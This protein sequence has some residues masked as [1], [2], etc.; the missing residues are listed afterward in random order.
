MLRANRDA[1]F[2]V[3]E[4]RNPAEVFFREVHV[5]IRTTTEVL[6]YVPR[7]ILPMVFS[8]EQKA[9]RR[10]I[11]TRLETIIAPERHQ[12]WLRAQLIRWLKDLLNENRGMPIP[13]IESQLYHAAEALGAEIRHDDSAGQYYFAE[14]DLVDEDGIEV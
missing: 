9:H 2:S 11:E 13:M 1:A 3:Y 5:Y 10:D 14:E 12:G 6:K 8:D 7:N 4:S